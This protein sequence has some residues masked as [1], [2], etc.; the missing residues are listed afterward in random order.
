MLFLGWA[1]KR[2]C[3]LSLSFTAFLV[4]CT[5]EWMS[6]LSYGKETLY[7]EL[8]PRLWFY[9]RFWERVAT[10]GLEFFHA[11]RVLLHQAPW[12]LSG[13]AHA[14]SLAIHL[15]FSLRNPAHFQSFACPQC[16]PRH[17]SLE[18]IPKEPR[19]EI[20]S[21]LSRR[22]LRKPNS[23]PKITHYLSDRY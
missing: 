23:F 5:R 22:S 3:A 9:L 6:G 13:Q 21:N 2:R 17:W 15:G 8:Y 11:Q 16:S 12:Q 4:V 1:R 18:V 19:E 7:T 20:L 10:S 14:I